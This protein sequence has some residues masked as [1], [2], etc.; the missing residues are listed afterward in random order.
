MIINVKQSILDTVTK[1]Q[2]APRISENSWLNCSE[3]S[4]FV[5]AYKYASTQTR[6]I[7]G[8]SQITPEQTYFIYEAIKRG[9]TIKL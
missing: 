3:Y 2:T 8:L 4:K 1:I 7:E 9:M 6:A 5:T